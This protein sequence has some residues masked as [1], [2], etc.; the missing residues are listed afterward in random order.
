MPLQGAMVR[1]SNF[2]HWPEGLT[3]EWAEAVFRERAEEQEPA[4]EEEL[5][6]RD[7]KSATGSTPS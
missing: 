6:P 7:R 1:S 3:G 4:D 5:R 2:G